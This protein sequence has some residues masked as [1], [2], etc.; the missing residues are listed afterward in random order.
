MRRTWHI[1]I[2]EL[3]QNLRDPLA[4]VFTIVMPLV[5][6]VFLGLLF[7]SGDED[8]GGLP[9]AIANRDGSPAAEA[10]VEV[11]EATPLLELEAMDAAEVDAAVQD[12]N[13]AAALIIPE[14]YGAA[15]EAGRAV[16]LTFV[17]IQTSSGAQSAWQA[18]ESVLSKS[19]TTVLA[20]EAAAEQVSLAT[21]AVV[22]DGLI[23]TARSLVEIE[24]RAPTVAVR[25]ES[26]GTSIA[27]QT[28]GFEQSS[29]GSLV[30]WVLFG[31]MSVGGTM[32]LERQRGLLRRLNTV[33]VRARE[34]IGGKM[35]AMFIVTFL[36]QLLL[37]LVGQ[38]AFGVDYF[39]NPPALLVIMVSLSVMAA[40]FGLLIACLFRTEGG[41]IA[42]NVITALLLGA[43][44]GAWFPLEVT[45]A[46]FTRV[47]HVLPSAWLM[48]SLNGITV[49]GWG[50]AEVLGPMGVVWIWIVV[51]FAVA[52]WR[53]RPD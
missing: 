36:Q 2:K 29:K 49:K 8:E 4:L 3:L 34:I 42:T 22:D 7:P 16:T 23:E 17:R 12:Q 37:V 13:V 35:L 50:F 52:V 6:M 20:A 45:N 33:G 26:G 25:T 19:N 11:L 1:V 48:D 15:M 31:V 41:F 10:L 40:A 47:A 39:N 46:G 27:A 14:G 44:G 18:V 21:G 51:L 9:V 24:L 43:L 30:Y 5:F 53:Y 38:L 32:V 28:G